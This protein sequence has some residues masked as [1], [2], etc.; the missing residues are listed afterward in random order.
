MRS[1]A[2]TY[3]CPS[4]TRRCVHARLTKHHGKVGP[5]GS[6][7]Y[8]GDWA[9]GGGI[10]PLGI[11]HTRS[12]VGLMED[13]APFDETAGGW[14]PLQAYARGGPPRG[15]SR[16]GVQFEGRGTHGPAESAGA[17]NARAMFRRAPRDRRTRRTSD[18]LQAHCE[19]VRL[20]R[21]GRGIR[22]RRALDV[23]QVLWYTANR[24]GRFTRHGIR[25][26]SQQ[27]E[28]PSEHVVRLD[29]L[30]RAASGV[31]AEAAER[32]HRGTRRGRRERSDDWP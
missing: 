22:R 23:Q 1:S 12:F 7:F 9:D 30:R 20:R 25:R 24:G 27:R 10:V 32:T 15:R 17:G 13:P 18:A 29:R 26:R 8:P 21:R 5:T 28:D 11:D 2:A 6:L 16:A 19:F 31:P 14:I 3:G 4:S